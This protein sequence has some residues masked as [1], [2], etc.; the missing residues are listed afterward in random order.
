MSNSSY[1]SYHEPSL[2]EL[3]ISST[4]L[5]ALNS[6]NSVLDRTLACG[7][8]GQVLLGTAWGQPGA[9]WLSIDF[10][11][12]VSSLGYLGLIL[13][14]YAG[15]LET[16]VVALRKN[17]V[18]SVAVAAT[19]VIVPIGLS[20]AILASSGSFLG[21]VDSGALLLP[22]FAAGAALCST[23]LGTTFS[24]LQASRLSRTRLGAVLASAALI[25][26]VVGL[27]MVRIITSLGQRGNE[28]IEPA[29]ILRPVLV[30]VAFAVVIPLACRYALKP[31]RRIADCIA[32]GQD[33]R[34]EEKEARDSDNK[35]RLRAWVNSQEAAFVF[36]TAFLILLVVAADY[37]GTSVL[38]AAYLAGVVVSWWGGQRSRPN[39]T[40][41]VVESHLRDTS[42]PSIEQQTEDIQ[43][44]V[45]NDGGSPI[46]EKSW[47]V[48]TVK[49]MALRVF[50]T[51]YAQVVAHVLKPFFF[52]SIGF[53]IPISKL[54]KGQIVWRGIIYSIL[55]IIGKL[56]CGLWLVRLPGSVPDTIRSIS[57]LIASKHSQVLSKI[58][59][60]RPV[61][62]TKPNS[63]S[64]LA[65]ETTSVQ[66]SQDL[67]LD[68]ATPSSPGSDSATPPKPLSLYP[69]AVMGCAMVARG[70]IGF[71]ISSMAESQGVFRQV[72][73]DASEASKFF[74][75]V[76]WAIFL[77][78]VAGPIGT[79]LLVRRIKKLEK[80]AEPSRG[81]GGR[82]VLGA[83]GFM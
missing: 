66:A 82:G 47:E 53:S 21:T 31:A 46:D 11:R 7:L 20:F 65:T 4:F 5:L 70:E 81:G 40:S 45:P 12:V 41:P 34:G 8:V 48:P 55:M 10:Q 19:G 24:V 79:G 58:R 72:D 2:V 56:V 25:D 42:P 61:P 29:T 28:R 75:I 44:P 37:A 62:K 71:L 15:G 22:A 30:S 16:D 74:L 36:Q 27:V 60:C 68:E 52:A 50:D 6:I 73:E 18:L 17:L 59:R 57:S 14:V 38:L 63:N 3:L 51:Y 78:T 9:Q 26:D 1:L 32:T 54:F 69:A 35:A 83:W 49:L 76:T 67:H 23:S 43:E 80:A 77:C 39:K 64:G 33:S 13:V